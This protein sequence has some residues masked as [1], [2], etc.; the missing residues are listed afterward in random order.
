[1][2][3]LNKKLLGTI[4]TRVP[5]NLLYGQGTKPWSHEPDEYQKIDHNMNE[6]EFLA[7]YD[8]SAFSTPLLTVDTVL[9]T[10]HEEQLKVLLV[11]R[12]D[13][14]D[15]NKWS[16]PGGFVDENRD[17]T[18]EDTVH[19]KL[20]EK[21]SVKTPYV[22]QLGTYGSAKRD[23]RGWSVTVVYTAMVAYQDCESGLQSIADV[24]WVSVDGL[25]TLKIAFDHATLIDAAWQRIRQKA[26]YSIVP[27]FTLPETFTLP[28]LQKV[29]EALIGKPLQKRSFTRRIIQAQLLEDTGEKRSEGGRAATLYRMKPDA[30]R[31]TFLRNL[32]V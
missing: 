1:M 28:M 32:E 6:K 25:V 3:I 30:G 10:Y 11:K 18:L 21:T 19:R 8:K 15:R 14:P 29:H 23:K 9:F 20:K 24:Q 26:L 31:Y 5:G 2:T 27:A 12:S 7:S 4:F 13:Y 17:R 16:L 22:E